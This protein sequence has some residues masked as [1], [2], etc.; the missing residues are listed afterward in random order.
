M[1]VEVG[2]EGLVPVLGDPHKLR[3]PPGVGQ[4][5]GESWWEALQ[6]P[7]EPGTASLAPISMGIVAK[8]QVSPPTWCARCEQTASGAK[9]TELF[10]WKI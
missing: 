3:L 4:Q 7:A 9:L 8:T 2:D 5:T 1:D 10:C 6:G